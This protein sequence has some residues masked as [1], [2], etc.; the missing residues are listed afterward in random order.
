[1]TVRRPTTGCRRRWAG[2][3]VLGRRVG[4]APTAPEPRRW[5]HMRVRNAG[6]A[7][8]T[9]AIASHVA[10]DQVSAPE[11]HLIPDSFEGDIFIVPDMPQGQVAK[12]VNGSI[13]FEIPPNG[14]LVTQDKLSQG[15]H[16][17][18]Y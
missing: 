6:F 16:F 17:T 4:R 10:C 13:V 18:E 3:E 11:I 7:L 8:I 2:W 14:I 12:R 5:A 15:W 1:M 9:V